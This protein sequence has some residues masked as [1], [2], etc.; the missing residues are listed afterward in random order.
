MALP[1]LKNYFDVRNAEGQSVGGTRYTQR[2]DA[3]TFA[4]A[5]FAQWPS[6]GK[7]HLVEVKENIVGVV[8]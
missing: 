7:L 3:E 8:K 1:F 5:W 6:S 2:S 4:R